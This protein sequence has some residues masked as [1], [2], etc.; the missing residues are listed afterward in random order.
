MRTAEKVEREA[1]SP[2]Q[3]R[4]LKQHHPPRLRKQRRERHPSRNLSLQPLLENSTPK[5]QLRRR[6]YRSR[7]SRKLQRKARKKTQKTRRQ[8]PQPKKLQPQSQCLS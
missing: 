6:G 8:L 7:R 2:T 3:L 4:E 5:Q 1:I